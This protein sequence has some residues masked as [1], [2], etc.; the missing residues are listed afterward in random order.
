MKIKTKRK[1][2][3]DVLALPKVQHKKPMR[4]L[5]LLRWLL[6]PVCFVLLKLAGFTHYE[7][8]G[9]ERLGK[10]EPCLIL[11]NH[12]S[13][14]DLEIA[15]FLLGDR[16]YHIVT[17]LDAFVG[18]GWILRL[19]GCIPT[20][21]FVND[22]NLVRDMRYTVKEL[23]ES[24]LMYPEASYS[25]DGTATPLPESLGK[26]LKLLNVPVVVIQTE[27]AFLRQPLYN[28]LK[29]RKVQISARMEYLLS[30]EDI[31]AKSVQELNDILAESFAFD[32]FKTQQEK[33][34]EIKETY[35]ADELH[36]VLYKCPHCHAEGQTVGKGIHLTCQ[37]CGASYELMETGFLQAVSGESLFNHI[38]DWYMW[39]R[40]CVRK[41]LEAGTYR[42]DVEV[43]IFM[44]V[45]TRCVFHVGSGR[46]V[47][48]VEGFH[49]TGC[50]G[51]LDYRQSPHASYGLYSDFYWYEIGDMICVGDEK[52]QYYC[53]PKNAGNVVAKTRLAAEELFK[54]LK[55]PAKIG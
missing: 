18:L 32:N 37:A 41:E 42:L 48:T 22:V 49:L 47:H 21:K 43:D 36:R 6:K 20:R 9:M 40:E 8:K 12:S 3:R 10:D 29:L 33:G 11:M 28:S 46:L 24:V 34:I 31:K 1:S 15:A 52:V 45:N 39:E 38:P 7:K 53:F 54:M 2:Y 5:V 55:R 25:F 50:D 26:C 17:T 19:L 16:A 4:Q 14:I 51:E 23:K 27:G 30:P 35:R 44:M 13:F